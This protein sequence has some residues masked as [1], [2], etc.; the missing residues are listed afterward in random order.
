MLPSDTPLPCFCCYAGPTGLLARKALVPDH[1]GTGVRCLATVCSFVRSGVYEMYIRLRVPWAPGLC[2]VAPVL[3]S[4]FWCMSNF[5][6]YFHFRAR[7]LLA[8]PAR[9]H[10]GSSSSSLRLSVYV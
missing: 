1:F 9:N 8:L 4:G 6:Q 10:P 2:C 5:L 3:G 7:G